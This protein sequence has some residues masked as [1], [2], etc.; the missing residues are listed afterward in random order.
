MKRTMVA[1]PVFLG[2]SK[3][4]G[5]QTIDSGFTIVELLIVIVVIAILAAITIVAYNGIQARANDSAVQSNLRQISQQLSIFYVDNSQYP[6]GG[7]L[8]SGNPRLQFSK[9]SYQ[10]SNNA[11]IYCRSSDGSQMAVI[12]KSQSGTTYYVTGTEPKV[13]VFG[14]SFPN[15]MAVDCPN[16]G[17][18]DYSTT[19][20]IHTSASGWVSWVNG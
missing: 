20:W 11:V 17:L 16:A 18:T 15:G 10:T 1:R 12:G 2:R 4:P 7:S 9:A 6:G 8:S 14:S 3:R 13:R 5:R 19:I